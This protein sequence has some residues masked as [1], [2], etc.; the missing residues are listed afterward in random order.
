M[1]MSQF[2]HHGFLVLRSAYDE[3]TI[4]DVLEAT[5]YPF[6]KQMTRHRISFPRDPADP[7]FTDAMET[8]FN[9]DRKA[10]IHCGKHAQHTVQ[11]H[12]LSLS[13]QSLGVLSDIGIAYPSICTRPVVYFNHPKIAEEEVYWKV[14]AHQD[15]RSMQGSLDSIVIWVPLVGIDRDMG[16]LQVSPGSHR[17]GLQTSS[18]ESGFGRVDTIGEDKFEDVILSRG[19]ALVF[20]S[21]L[22]HRSGNNIDRRIR[23]SA[24]FRYN[25]MDEK[26]FIER[27]YP[28]P[29][30]YRPEPEL[31]TPD[32]PTSSD[33]AK[34]F[35]HE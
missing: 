35:P 34:Q 30:S 14:F 21:F 12:T 11:L 8:L 33:I 18:V 20:S 32:F 23:W 5:A 29:Y 26:T 2:N 24:H 7:D 22:V 27:G 16:A 25:N 13:S 31:I 6:K 9:T 17:G 28:Q 10:F 1:D 15:W 4:N 19:D 3:E